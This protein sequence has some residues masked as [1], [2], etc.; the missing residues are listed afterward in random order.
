MLAPLKVSERAGKRKWWGL[1]GK[2]FSSCFELYVG[3]NSNNSDPV[4]G[5]SMEG[6]TQAEGLGQTSGQHKGT[7]TT[8]GPTTANCHVIRPS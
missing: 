2:E 7:A 5:E 8:G 6:A 1:T 3:F 4:V